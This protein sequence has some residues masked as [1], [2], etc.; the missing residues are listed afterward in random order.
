MLKVMA[1]ARRM[2]SKILW[3]ESLTGGTAILLSLTATKLLLHLVF[4]GRYG[5]FRDE[6]YYIACAEHLAWGYV[7]QPPLIALMARL[8]RS[9]LGDS[10]PA[11]RFFP[12]LAGACV[13]FLAGRMARELGGGRFAQGLAALGMLVAPA[14]LAFDSFLSMNAFEP[15]F[16]MLCAYLV[17][18]I[19]NDGNPKLWLLVGPAAGVGLLNK[20]TMLAF[21]FALVVGLL[22][23]PARVQLRSKWI[24][25][26]GLVALVIFLPNLLWEAT[27]QWPQVE[28]VRNAQRFKNFPIP[29]LQFLVEQVIFLHPLTFPIWV[30]GLWFYFFAKA[31]K[32]FRCLGWA[33]LI[34]LVL[35]LGLRG[36]TYYLLPAYPMLF[37]AGAVFLEQAAL[38]PEWRWLKPGVVTALVL[39]GLVTLPYGLPVLPV[40]SFIRYEKMV[41]IARS[42]RTERDPLGELPQLYADMFGWE[43]MVATVARVYRDL[44]PQDRVKCAIF[45]ENYGEAG[46]IDFFGGTQGLPKAISGHNNYWFWGPGS[47]TGEIVISVG[48]PREKLER[49]FGQIEQVATISSLYAMPVETNL[50][51]YLCREP[52]APLAQLWPLTR[53]YI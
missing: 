48:V 37:A 45:T 26:A 38:A 12:A 51:V 5:Y 17:M 7:D 41:P 32:R 46:A 21:G 9:L 2:L 25:L 33:Y 3:R 13:L 14:V 28:V 4:S 23:T 40:D 27:H 53:Y 10:L 24:W 35:L 47:Y 18:R 29:P 44:P 49:M 11:L 43:N 34:L 20:H 19:L 31:G 22:L 36:K 16:W 50:P 15:L 6:L 30:G 42:V 52:K 1:T 8:A 39:G